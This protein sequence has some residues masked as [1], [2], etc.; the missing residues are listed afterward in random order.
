MYYVRGRLCDE[1]AP[2]TF[3]YGSTPVFD[4]WL[5]VEGYWCVNQRVDHESGQISETIAD[6]LSESEALALAEALNAV[7][8]RWWLV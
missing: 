3:S 6:Q 5:H 4:A 8:D 1:K 2:P 7:A